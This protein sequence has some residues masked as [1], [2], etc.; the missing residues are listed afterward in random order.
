MKYKVS[1]IIPAYNASKTIEKCIKSLL[2]QTLKDIEIIV[3][4]DCSTDNTVDVVKNFKDSIVLIKNKTNLGP[5]ASRNR[6]L[7]EARGEYIGF[8]DADDY[9]DKEMYQTMVN[10]MS[11]EIDLVCSSRYNVI[12][13]ELKPIIN[14]NKTDNPKEFSK[15]SSYVWDKL[16]KKILIDQHQLTFPE[17]YSY[18]EDF[19]FLMKYKYYANKMVIL[20]KPLCYYLYDSEASITNSYKENLFHI[21]AVLE[22]IISFFK[23]EGKFEEYESELLEISAGFYVRRIKEFRRYTDTNLQ[24]RFVKTFLKYFKRNFKQYKKVVNR[25]QTKRVKAYRSHY[26]AM[27]LFIWK[28][29]LGR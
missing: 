7:K 28:Q 1:V 5:S 2:A 21:I 18:A 17:E 14:Q 15:T 29:K 3:I 22:D 8:V 19:Y 20:D 23:E 6:G 25:F 9:V 26:W 13:G 12:K 11:D 24:K 16:F 27:C 10:C 4:D